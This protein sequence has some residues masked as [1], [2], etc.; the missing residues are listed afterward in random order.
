VVKQVKCEALST[1]I[2]A[3]PSGIPVPSQYSRRLLLSGDYSD[4]GATHQN[5]HSGVSLINVSDNGSFWRQLAALLYPDTPLLLAVAASALAA[6]VVGLMAPGVTGEL[7]N[8]IAGHLTT[9]GGGGGGETSGTLAVMGL[10]ALQ[11]PA[12]KLLRL[13][14][15][16]GLCTW[17]HISLVGLLGERVA[18][19]LRRQAYASVLAQDMVWFDAQ[20]A[21]E[22]SARVM[23]DV[24]EFKVKYSQFPQ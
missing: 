18:W 20:R 4:A 22:V 5:K 24:A 8:V 14:A 9:T 21:G 15:L 16:Q 3:P 11:T 10:R 12:L 6:A 1:G 23:Q 2:Y 7:V 17:L 19:R 13:F